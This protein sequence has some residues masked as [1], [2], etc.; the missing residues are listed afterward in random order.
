[1]T[2]GGDYPCC[3]RRATLRSPC[4]FGWYCDAEEQC[5]HVASGNLGW[6]LLGNNIA[7]EH[8]GVWY[9]RCGKRSPL[10]HLVSREGRWYL[11]RDVEGE[12]ARGE[13]PVVMEAG[14]E[15]DTTCCGDSVHLIATRERDE[16]DQWWCLAPGQCAHVTASFRQKHPHAPPEANN[17][18][19][20]AG[21]GVVVIYGGWW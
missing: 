3:Q 2:I 11:S 13:E 16:P 7:V 15:V 12:H 20:I 21:S 1:M 9:L 5:A 17:I 10:R 19:M 14:A 18:L 8:E 6:S 4:E